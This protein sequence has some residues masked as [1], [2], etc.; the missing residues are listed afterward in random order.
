M[1]TAELQS[2]L[3]RG[4]RL[5][6]GRKSPRRFQCFNPR[7]RTGNDPQRF[8][9]V[10]DKV[11]SIHA[12]ARGATNVG[13]GNGDHAGLQS[14]LP[15]GER[16]SM[17]T[18]S[19]GSSSSFNPRSRTGSDCA[20]YAQL[21]TGLCFNPRSRAGSD[22][23]PAKQPGNCLASIHAPVRGATCQAPAWMRTMKLQSTLPHGERLVNYRKGEEYAGFNPRSRAGSDPVLT[24][25]TSDYTWLQS[26]LPCGERRRCG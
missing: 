22:E 1:E 14:T 24:V 5:A 19:G 9:A 8:L 4:E 21:E 18:S 13:A 26:T 15:H 16:H 3:P 2:T 23:I 10:G 6:G 17:Y 25:C 20:G 7:S 12:P 11:A